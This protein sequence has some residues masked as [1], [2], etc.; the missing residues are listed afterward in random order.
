MKNKKKKSYVANMPNYI[1]WGYWAL[2][3]SVFMYLFF[4]I[5]IGKTQSLPVLFVVP[6]FIGF[7]LIYLLLPV[8]ALLFFVNQLIIRVTLFSVNRNH[9]KKTVIVIGKDEFKNPSYWV[10]PNY[11]L[12]LLLIVKYLKIKNED[13]SIYYNVDKSK[14]DEIMTNKDIKTVYLVG[15]GRRHGFA[16][17]K[18]EVVDYCNYNNMNKYKKDFVYQIHCNHGKGK[19]LVEYVVPEENRTECLPEHGF[20]SNFSITEMF[21]DKIIEYKGY[22]KVKRFLYSLWYNAIFM[23]GA[24]IVFVLWLIILGVIIA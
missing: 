23:S 21:V 15:H 16:L 5:L 14:L 24:V 6:M 18:N 13:F 8:R 17:S 2:L 22:G 4:K 1:T 7:I 3:I 19:S 9:P 12:D 10:S 20:M 11:D